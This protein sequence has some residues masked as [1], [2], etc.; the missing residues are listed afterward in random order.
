VSD[1]LRFLKLFMLG[2]EDAYRKT[3]T[4]TAGQGVGLSDTIQQARQ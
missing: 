1:K 4:E 2:T 3:Q